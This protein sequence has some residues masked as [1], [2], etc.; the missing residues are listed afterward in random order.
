M[1]MKGA[2]RILNGNFGQGSKKESIS[3]QYIC[4]YKSQTIFIG[5]L[6]FTFDSVI[7][8]QIVYENL[9]F[10]HISVNVYQ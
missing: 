1:V 10:C 9:N 8:P 2:G 4:W 5:K 7:Y 3:N 6:Y